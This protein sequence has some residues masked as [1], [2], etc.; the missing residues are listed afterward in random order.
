[1]S[2]IYL[3]LSHAAGFTLGMFAASQFKFGEPIEVYRW[4][5]AIVLF[6]FFGILGAVEENR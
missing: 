5:I 6:V 3:F 1:M 2:A 4:V